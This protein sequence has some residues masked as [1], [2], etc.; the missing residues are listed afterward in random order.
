MARRQV[1]EVICDR[2]GKTETQEPSQEAKSGDGVPELVVQFQA[3][4][5]EYTDLCV[6]C[7]DACENYF[8]SITKQTEKEK[9][10]PPA[11]KTGLLGLG[12]RKTG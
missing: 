7:R 4:R 1:V 3:E 10:A 5:H 12:G 9:E 6:R 8:K 2:C 11:K